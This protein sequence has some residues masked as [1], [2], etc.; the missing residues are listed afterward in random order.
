[1]LCAPDIPWVKDEYREAADLELRLKIFE[2]Y[3]EIMIS[4]HTPWKII[5]GDFE[6]RFAQ[7]IKAVDELFQ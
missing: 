7:A 4:Q 2:H 5:N 1:L 6:T 3:K